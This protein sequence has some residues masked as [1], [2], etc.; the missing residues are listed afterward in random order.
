MSS[1]ILYLIATPIGNLEDI[2]LRA[3][4]ILKEVKVIACEDTRH[5]K[6]LLDH[7]EIRG[8]D[9]IS[10]HSYSGEAKSE[11]ILQILKSGVDIAL[12][13]DAGTPGISD[14]GTALVSEVIQ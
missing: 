13:S 11:I 14:P 1:G 6:I 2:T 8:K 12:C 9:L 4:R 7:Y 3:L 10:Y 5:T